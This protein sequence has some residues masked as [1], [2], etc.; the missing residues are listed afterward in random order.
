MP[1]PPVDRVE[2]VVCTDGFADGAGDDSL[3]AEEPS[4]VEGDVIVSGGPEDDRM[5][6]DAGDDLLYGCDRKAPNAQ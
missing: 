4:G 1:D 3:V 6:D 5:P 2:R